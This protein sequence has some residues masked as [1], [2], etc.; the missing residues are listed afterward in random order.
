MLYILVSCYIYLCVISLKVVKEKCGRYEVLVVLI[1]W[2]GGGG[3][4]GVLIVCL[5]MVVLFFLYLIC[6]YS[7]KDWSYFYW[8]VVFDNIYLWLMIKDRI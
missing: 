1:F 7:V 2:G 4:K 5:W 3:G 8:F 6:V